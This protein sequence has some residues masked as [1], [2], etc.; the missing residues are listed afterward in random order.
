MSED[1]IAK[2]QRA[3]EAFRRGD[4]DAALTYAIPR[5]LRKLELYE[6][7]RSSSGVGLGWRSKTSWISASRLLG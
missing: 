6:E 4:V 2:L 1:Y 5:V 3:Y 7:A